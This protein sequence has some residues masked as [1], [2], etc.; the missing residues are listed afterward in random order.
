MT[1]T[2]HAVA[3][4]AIAGTLSA[5]PVLALPLAFLSH[6]LLDAIPHWD[7]DLKSA[8]KFVG[9]STGVELSFGKDFLIDVL[10]VGT[11]LSL[12][13]VLA[14]LVFYIIGDKQI[15]ILVLAGALVAVL[16]D[17]MQF[18]YGKLKT[19]S[20][21]YFQSWHNYFHA[22]LRLDNKPVLGILSQVLIVG[23]IIVW[24]SLLKNF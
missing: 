18:A 1:L 17:F 13:L 4:A 5:Y 15:G 6:F 3:G 21:A 20:L 22:S 7:Y 23:L 16:P 9:E 11:D 8:K 19:K 14:G 2:T 12:G 24:V 10:R